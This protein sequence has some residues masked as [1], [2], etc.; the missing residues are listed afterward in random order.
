MKKILAVIIL[1]SVAF[2]AFPLLSRAALPY[3]SAKTNAAPALTGTADLKFVCL[4]VIA[5]VAATLPFYSDNDGNGN[6]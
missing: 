4:A 6:A 2:T 3:S 1:L 5:V